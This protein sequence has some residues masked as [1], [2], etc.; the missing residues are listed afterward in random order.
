[1][2]AA[3]RI[4]LFVSYLLIV[5][6]V[7]LEV[8]VR[9]WGYSRPYI[10]DPIYMLYPASEEIPYVH[11]P[12]LRD[13]RGRGLSIVHTDALGLRTTTPG[14]TYGPKQPAEYRIAVAGNSVTFGQG[15]RDAEDTFC[16][17]LGR[18]LND[19]Q[20]DVR[21]TVFNYGASAYSVREMEATLRHRMLEVEPDLVVMAIITNDFFP[22]RSVDVDRWGYHVNRRLSGWIPKDSR[23][24]RWLRGVHLTY[25]VR[26][27][28]YQWIKK[29]R[30]DTDGVHRYNLSAERVPDGYR[31]VSRFGEQA[32]ENG[33]DYLIVL[34][35]C[36]SGSYGSVPR[37]LTEDGMA[38]A[39]LSFIRG[40][41]TAREFA[42]SKFDR[43][44]SA[45]VHRRI[46]EELAGVILAGPLASRR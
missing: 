13:A 35:P 36:H 23:L 42:A 20:S 7:I 18:T 9:V 2:R 26:D 4:V 43:H 31:Y 45:A 39:D 15:V 25:V 22:S 28:R 5:I 29:R 3:A 21:I 11:K 1:M 37:Q 38:R 41:F 40:E 44:P 8:G 46:G 34:L 6:V 19:A 10:Y 32:V 30:G 24:K 16:E 12:N 17:V 33:V 27:L 14:R